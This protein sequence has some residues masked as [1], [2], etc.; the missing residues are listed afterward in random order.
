M[1]SILVPTDFSKEAKHAT[2]LAMQLATK[3]KASIHFIHVVSVPMD[4][5]KLN[6]QD[7]LY[8]EVTRKIN[9]INNELS[10]L[11]TIAENAGLRTFTTV[12]YKDSYAEILK[13]LKENNIDLIVM[14]SKGAS[15][16]KELLIGS[17]TEKII[18]HAQCPV[19]VVKEHMDLDK[20][21]RIMMPTDLEYEQ[22]NIA[23]LVNTWVKL[24]GAKLYLVKVNINYHWI[25]SSGFINEI[26]S[27]AREFK[28]DTYQARAY[29][30]NYL[31]DGIV[32]AAKDVKADLIIMGTHSR[33]GIA[34]IIAGSV[35]EDVANQSKSL[36]M[37]QAIN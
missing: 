24:L 26:E 19:L 1:K 34:H 28:I 8:P 15:G 11:K 17:N 10:N 23:K 18:R 13:Y 14:G 12:S 33:T 5:V 25:D 36:I 2:H 32:Q 7:R 37:T 35:A 4:W 22:E 3:L 20:I 29:D 30:A 21:K 6:D 31:E 9:H 27:F 16:I